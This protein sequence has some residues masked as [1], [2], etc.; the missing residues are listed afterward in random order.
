MG[1]CWDLY[2]YNGARY[3][4]AGVKFT[5]SNIT[6][7]RFSNYSFAAPGIM[8]FTMYSPCLHNFKSLLKPQVVL[9]GT[10]MTTKVYGR[11]RTFGPVRFSL[12]N[13]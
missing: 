1:F 7:L 11:P 13:Q 6:S 9:K 3:R 12:T 5:L 4:Q 10:I 8:K 2:S